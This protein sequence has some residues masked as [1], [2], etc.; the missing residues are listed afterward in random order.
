MKKTT[1]FEYEAYENGDIYYNNEKVEYRKSIK[2]M[3]ENKILRSVSYARFVYY[4]FHQKDFDFNNYSY[5]VRHKDD[6]EQNNSID[7]LYSTNTKDY[8]C[9]E[10]HKMSKLT[11][12]Q[13]QEI[14]DLYKRGQDATQDLNSP[15]KKISYRKL[16]KMYGV[17]HNTIRRI[18][19][20]SE[21]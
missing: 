21:M 6:D 19:K 20:K 13:M 18:V 10:K 16:A 7:N 15:I 5:V 11:D 12:K 2:V 14:Q 8:L 3:W 1:L 4:A 9:G 17:N